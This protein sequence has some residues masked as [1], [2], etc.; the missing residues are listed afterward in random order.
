MTPL[1]AAPGG[2][3]EPVWSPDGQRI[4]FTS[5]RDGR[6]LI[7]VLDLLS[8]SVKRLTEPSAGSAVDHEP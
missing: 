2:D 8:S 1:P 3:S 4:A 7:Y 6:P 5:L